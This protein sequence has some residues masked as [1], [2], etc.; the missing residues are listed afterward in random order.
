MSDEDRYRVLLYAGDS[1]IEVKPDQTEDDARQIVIEWTD[2]DLKRRCVCQP[3]LPVQEPASAEGSTITVLPSNLKLVTYETSIGEINVVTNDDIP[4]D[5]FIGEL[6]LQ[7]A[8]ALGKQVHVER[9]NDGVAIHTVIINDR[10]EHNTL[11]MAEI[12]EFIQHGDDD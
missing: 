4:A 5:S 1:L 12:V 2:E 10:V 9:V 3:E 8:Q 11:D 7:V 6:V